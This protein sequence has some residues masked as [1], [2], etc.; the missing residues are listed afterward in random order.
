VGRT[1]SSARDPLVALPNPL[2]ALPN[3]LIIGYGNSLRGGDDGAG[4]FVATR[5]IQ[6]RASAGLHRFHPE[7]LLARSQQLYGRAPEAVLI[8][9]EAL[10]AIRGWEPPFPRWKGG[11]LSLSVRFWHLR[12][13]PVRRPRPI[14]P[15]SNNAS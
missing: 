5:P 10:R 2:V 14:L 7:T 12:I 13:S 8:A 6:P 9:R 4:P 11:T 15:D 3:P 1:P